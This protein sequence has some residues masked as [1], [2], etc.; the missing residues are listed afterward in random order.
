MAT[1]GFITKSISKQLTQDNWHVVYTCIPNTPH[2][3]VVPIRTSSISSSQRYPDIVA[4]KGDQTLF[5]EVEIKLNSNVK[6]QMI[7]RFQDY[8]DALKEKENWD[9]WR[10]QLNTLTNYNLPSKF[11]PIAL[12]II[13]N[14][15]SDDNA[16]LINDLRQNKILCF[17]ASTFDISVI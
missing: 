13:C 9:I 10:N 7:E 15:I 17:T 8:I 3:N 11:N 6:D 4:Y 2:I 1:Q 12:L 14:N 16:T 5:V